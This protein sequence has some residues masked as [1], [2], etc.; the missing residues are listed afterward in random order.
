MPTQP[1]PYKV[2]EKEKKS[3]RTKAELEA[4][5]KK[6]NSVMSG[7]KLKER[8]EVKNNRDA[9]LEFL[10]IKKLLAGID[11]MDDIYGS[12]INRYCLMTAECKDLEQKKNEWNERLNKLECKYDSLS[13]P[14]DYISYSDFLHTCDKIEK[15]IVNLDRLIQ[16]KRKELFAIE[17]ENYM[18]IQSAIRNI[19]KPEEV[20]DDSILTVLRRKG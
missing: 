11:K 8:I 16:A 18:T 3:H 14:D 6:E 5:K 4:R 20:Q 7:V 1:K 12:V 9:H 15:N 19:P 2:L 17:R 10:R 13:N